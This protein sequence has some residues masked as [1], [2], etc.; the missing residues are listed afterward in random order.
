MS[1]PEPVTRVAI[2]GDGV[3]A[4][5]CAHLLREAGIPL[6]LTPPSSRSRGAVLLSRQTLELLRELF[7]LAPLF[8][9]GAAHPIFRRKVLWG[10][11]AVTEVA[12]TAIAVREAE[13]LRVLWSARPKRP[14]AHASSPDPPAFRL[15]CAAPPIGVAMQS[16]GSTFAQ[17][18]WAR[19]NS[20]AD[21][22]ACLIESTALGWLFLLPLSATEA[23][24]LTVGSDQDSMLSASRLVAHA[25]AGVPEP[26]A[27][28]PTSPRVLL[29]PGGE[30]WLACGTAAIGF[31]PLCGE[32]VGHA[33]REAYFVAA[34]IRAQRSGTTFQSLLE[35]YSVRLTH[36]MLRHL[37]IC[38]TYYQG[39]GT[40]KFWSEQLARIDEGETW[41][42]SASAHQKLP[43]Y[44]LVDR[45]VAAG[46]HAR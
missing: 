22:H 7:D 4:A 14:E 2:E 37:D 43:A 34:M 20:L 27:V 33:V 26:A 30:G 21:P 38:R 25:I 28:F 5:C 17:G 39:G 18:S 44:R 31:D 46:P 10:D 40:G 36:G 6:D 15:Y 13:L 35:D 32:G 1:V 19:L 11:T 24:L 9:S 12:H 23:S 3:S 41:L 42:R 45:T 8:S 16:F 29:P